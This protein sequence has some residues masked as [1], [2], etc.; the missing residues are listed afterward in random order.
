VVVAVPT[1]HADAAGKVANVADAVYCANL[2]SGYPFAVADAYRR[3]TDVS[4]DEAARD[5]RAF[6]R[7]DEPGS[8][9]GG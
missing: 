8:R 5:L 3:W 6:A 1:A 9:P 4:E 7:R 2:R